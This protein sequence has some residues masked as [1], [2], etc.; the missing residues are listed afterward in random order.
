MRRRWTIWRD[1]RKTRARL[2]SRNFL[3]LPTGASVATACTFQESNTALPPGLLQQ[4]KPISQTVV[5]NHLECSARLESM[6]H[7][8]VAPHTLPSAQ[9]LDRRAALA[10]A[11]FVL[12]GCRAPSAILSENPNLRMKDMSD[13]RFKTYQ[14]YLSAWSAIPDIERERLLRESVSEAIVFT[15]PTQTRR[16]VPDVIA[17]LRGFQV[18][19]PGGSFR[20]NEMLGWDTHGI[21][22]WQFVDGQNQPG[23]WGYDVLAFDGQGR[24]ESILLFSHVEKQMLK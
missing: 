3:S 21:A 6:D 14:T 11:A 13:P 12:V 19:S 22:T 15:N 17:H 24:I 8:E 18:R 7:A 5:V 20:M 1:S 10:V 16:G 2:K 9:T 23:F 4:N